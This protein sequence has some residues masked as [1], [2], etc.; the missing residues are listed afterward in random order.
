MPQQ[1]RIKTPKGQYKFTAQRTILATIQN[2]YYNTTNYN[3][4]KHKKP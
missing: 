1:N 3:R 2:N 4:T